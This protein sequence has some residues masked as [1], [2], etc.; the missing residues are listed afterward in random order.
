MKGRWEVQTSPWDTFHKGCKDLY[1]RDT[2]AY[3]TSPNQECPLNSQR[4]LSL[5]WPRRSW[6]IL[7]S[8]GRKKIMFIPRGECRK[9]TSHWRIHQMP[10]SEEIQLFFLL[11]STCIYPKPKSRT[12]LVL[13]G[14][15]VIKFIYYYSYGYLWGDGSSRPCFECVLYM[16]ATKEFLAET[17]QRKAYGKNV[18]VPFAH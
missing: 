2:A 15:L 6:V 10:N 12:L 14:S 11:S 5:W 17:I 3:A 7:I 9:P 13:S 18:K 4:D 16:Q 8:Q 1:Q